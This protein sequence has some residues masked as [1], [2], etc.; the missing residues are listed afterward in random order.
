MAVFPSYSI[1]R[2]RFS[3]NRDRSSLNAGRVLRKAD[4]SGRMH[5][6]VRVLFIAAACGLLNHA[7]PA[8]AQ[9]PI[10]G[11]FIQR[12]Q[13]PVRMLFLSLRPEA[14][15]LLPQDARQWAVRMDFAN[16]YALTRPV[17][18]PTIAEDYYQAAP[19][20]EYRLF[21]DTETL[22]LAVDLDWRIASRLQ[23][24]LTLPFLKHGGGFLDGTVEGFHKLFNLTNGG[25]EETARN[26]YGVYVAR[27][28]RFWIESGEPA[29]FRPGDLVLRLKTPLY[30]RAGVIDLALSSA[31][32][33]PTGNL[34][35]LTGSGG[36]DILAAVFA[37][38]QP[39][40]TLSIHYNIAHSRLGRPSRSEGF[41]L[42]SI[43]THMLAFE[44][45]A[46][47][48]LAALIQAQGNT[49]PFPDSVLGPLD[50]AAFEVTAGARLALSETMTL[51]LGLTENLSQYQN[52]PDIGIHAGILWRQP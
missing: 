18:D 12:D 37:T 46:T 3:L 49:G 23:I 20:N 27:N 35:A 15:A 31:V 26:S 45:R 34:D 48:R 41:P 30:R 42:R 10:T 14:G 9:S 44:Y 4:I 36:F 29:A 52:T 39:V 6:A 11:P 28:G 1:L 16:T 40:R 2:A 13:F 5:A 17:G 33:L 43:T 47:D 21:A 24:G 25:R 32:K 22:R 19:P 50:R 8:I 7:M 38:W 51:E